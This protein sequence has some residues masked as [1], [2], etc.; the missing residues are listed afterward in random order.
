MR[1]DHKNKPNIPSGA[2]R[3]IIRFAWL[4]TKIAMID[5]VDT[6]YINVWLEKYY[7]DQKYE[8]IVKYSPLKDFYNGFGWKNEGVGYIYKDKSV[9]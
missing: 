3:R 4:P 7:Q 2:Q 1:W 5:R 9:V 6:K 8:L